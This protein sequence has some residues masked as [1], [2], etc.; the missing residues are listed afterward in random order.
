[1]SNNGEIIENRPGPINVSVVSLSNI[2]KSIVLEVRKPTDWWLSKSSVASGRVSTVS[3]T[4]DTRMSTARGADRIGTYCEMFLDQHSVLWQDEMFLETH[5][6][7]LQMAH[8][9]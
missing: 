4:A 5:A 2:N 6:S 7:D 8:M 1:M 3:I 9:A